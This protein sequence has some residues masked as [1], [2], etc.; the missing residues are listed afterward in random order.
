MG[1]T[2]PVVLSSTVSVGES[3]HPES[4]QLDKLDVEIK[5]EGDEADIPKSEEEL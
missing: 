1:F 5:H 2:A 4:R 3:F